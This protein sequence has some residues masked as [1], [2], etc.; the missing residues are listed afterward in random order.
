MIFCAA[1]FAHAQV[2]YKTP[3]VN[4]DPP[5]HL[6]AFSYYDGDRYVKLADSYID[7]QL[8]DRVFKNVHM[9][10]PFDVILCIKNTSNRSVYVPRQ[11]F[12]WY[13]SGFGSDRY[14][15]SSSDV[16]LPGKTKKIPIHVKNNWREFFQKN[17][18]IALFTSDT[19]ELRYKINLKVHFVKTDTTAKG[20]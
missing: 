14:F 13:D 8:Q 6:V 16:L 15:F 1:H 10:D 4:N 20:G 12:C 17:G 19:T 5:K 11:I 7:L 2:N 3:N 18:F 9:Q